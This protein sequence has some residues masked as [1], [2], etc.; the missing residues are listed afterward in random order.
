MVMAGTTRSSQRWQGPMERY[1]AVLVAKAP[2]RP[3]GTLPWQ[4][5][6]CD[7][8]VAL[9]Q[10]A[11]ARLPLRWQWGVAVARYVEA[12]VAKPCWWWRGCC[13]PQG[14]FA[15]VN[16]DASLRGNDQLRRSPRLYGPH[17]FQGCDSF[18]ACAWR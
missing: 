8:R 17:C 18:D 6:R 16:V 13:R 5:L 14:T 11:E 1:V 4:G 10:V 15:A 9:A 2:R 12:L 7:P 3:R